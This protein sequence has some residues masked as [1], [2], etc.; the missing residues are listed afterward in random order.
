LHRFLTEFDFRYSNRVALKVDDAQRAEIA[1]KGIR[2]KRLTYRR[3]N[4]ARYA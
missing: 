4:E 2:G 3:N 1:L